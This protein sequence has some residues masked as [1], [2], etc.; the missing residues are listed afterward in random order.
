MRSSLLKCILLCQ[1]PTAVYV[2]ISALYALLTVLC[3]SLF[4][5]PYISVLGVAAVMGLYTITPVYISVINYHRLSKNLPSFAANY[6]FS[7]LMLGVFVLPMLIC[8]GVFTGEHFMNT[9]SMTWGLSLLSV[10]YVFALQTV[11]WI[12]ACVVRCCKKQHDDDQKDGVI[13]GTGS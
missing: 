4:D 6:L 7:L 5:F 2:F 8:G 11:S 3:R 9:Q 1:I 13:P 12:I 10:I